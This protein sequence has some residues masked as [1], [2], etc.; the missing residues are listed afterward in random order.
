MH[1]IN[2]ADIAGLRAA[3]DTVFVDAR[4]GA[5]AFERFSDGHLED[6]LFVD[7]ETELSQKTSDAADGGR[8]PLPS[9]ADFGKLLGTLGIMPSTAVVVYDDKKGANAAARFWWMLRAAGHEKVYVVNGGWDGIV[10]AGLPV[11]TDVVT[12]LTEFPSYP[13]VGWELPTVSADQVA[14]VAESENGMI[15]D[16]RERYRF[17]GE[18]EPIDLVA[19]HIPGAINI[20]YTGNLDDKGDFLSAYELGEKYKEALGETGTKKV[21]IHCG[22]GVT[23]CHTILAFAEADLP[24]PSLYVGSWSEWSRNDRPVAREE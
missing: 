6:A 12:L 13:I 9:P 16:V 14:E 22:S 5:D 20:P 21:I 18:S 23:A 17:R 3:G 2:P 4:G 1:I 19:G 7:L 10:A 15:I 8:H 11:T 24:T